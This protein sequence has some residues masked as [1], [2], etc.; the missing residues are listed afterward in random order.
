MSTQ[1]VYHMQRAFFFSSFLHTTHRSSTQRTAQIQ[2]IQTK[3]TAKTKKSKGKTN[4]EF[5]VLLSEE[6]HV[7]EQFMHGDVSNLGIAEAMA[8]VQLKAELKACAAGLKR[9]WK[10][11][12]GTARQAHRP[13]IKE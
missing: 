12:S 10:Q 13:P 3:R 5:Q 4:H 6:E 1:A 2:V 8:V 9:V 7:C 11:K